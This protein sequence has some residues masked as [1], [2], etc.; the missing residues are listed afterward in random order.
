MAWTKLEPIKGGHGGCLH[1]GYQYEV[2]PLDGGG[3]IAVGFGY[4]A[5]H[6]GKKVVFSEDS[7]AEWEDAM[8]FAD[9]EALAKK[10]PN[11][12]WRIVL[13]APLS[14][15]TYQR[16]G[17]GHWALVKKGSGFA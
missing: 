17:V 9:A 10:D 4:A 1:C 11:H 2:L 7:D 3:R 15:R 16:H 6:K 13:D 5:L 8:T 14:T 12:D